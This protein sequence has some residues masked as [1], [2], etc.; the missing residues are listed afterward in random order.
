MHNLDD[1]L[2]LIHV[3]VSQL[4]HREWT[5]KLYH[6]IFIKNLFQDSFCMARMVCIDAKRGSQYLQG[7]RTAIC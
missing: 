6:E 1:V 5:Y 2:L 3:T 7:D 4:E